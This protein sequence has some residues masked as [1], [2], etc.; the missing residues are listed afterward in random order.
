MFI[1][2]PTHINN[3]LTPSQIPLNKSLTIPLKNHLVP[4]Y[5]LYIRFMLTT[6]YYCYFIDIMNDDIFD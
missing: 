2:P 4:L 3:K 5:I 6:K 1:T